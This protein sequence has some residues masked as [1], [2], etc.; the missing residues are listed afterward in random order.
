MEPYL[1][2][3]ICFHGVFKG[4][5]PFNYGL[6]SLAFTPLKKG[7]EQGYDRRGPAFHCSSTALSL[8]VFHL[9]QVARLGDEF[10][11]NLK[12]LYFTCLKTRKGVVSL[13]GNV[14]QMLTVTVQ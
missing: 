3:P 7:V 11:F 1:R 4:R 6:E 10:F 2:S 12:L 14:Q 13:D 5:V 8:I 9:Q